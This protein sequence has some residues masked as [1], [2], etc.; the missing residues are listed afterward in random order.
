MSHLVGRFDIFS[1]K[2]D[3]SYIREKREA[4]MLTYL[5]VDQRPCISFGS[6]SML[7]GDLFG[8]S[9]FFGLSFKLNMLDDNARLR[10][11]EVDARIV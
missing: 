1:M 10:P 4:F 8:G 2:T 9:C 11:L 7:T 5:S 3:P 6:L